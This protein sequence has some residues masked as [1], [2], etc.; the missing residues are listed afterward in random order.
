MGATRVYLRSK[1]LPILVKDEAAVVA[2]AVRIGRNVGTLVKFT[3]ASR[4][5]GEGDIFLD[6][7]EVIGVRET[8]EVEAPQND[9]L[10]YED[11][12]VF[13]QSAGSVEPDFD[14]E[15]SA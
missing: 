3:A 8:V 4:H 7:N 9:G 11:G 6:P 15:P 10:T 5:L 12:A 2:D 13:D 1:K 14:P